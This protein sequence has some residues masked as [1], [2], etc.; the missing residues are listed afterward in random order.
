MTREETDLLTLEQRVRLRWLER[1][2]AN[3]LDES[4]RVSLAA[5]RELAGTAPNVTSATPD[6]LNEEITAE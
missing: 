4:E 2:E 5:L 3:G 1:K 6:P